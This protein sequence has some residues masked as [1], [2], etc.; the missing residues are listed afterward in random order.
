MNNAAIHWSCVHKGVV[1]TD[2]WLFYACACVVLAMYADEGLG[3]L[4]LASDES[5]EVRL[6]RFVKRHVD[7]IRHAGRK[8]MHQWW[9]HCAV[10][11]QGGVVCLVH[12][13][14]RHLTS[15][16]RHAL[17]IPACS[18]SE[19]TRVPMW[20][21]MALW[22]IE[23]IQMLAFSLSLAADSEGGECATSSASSSSVSTGGHHLLRRL[24]GSSTTATAPNNQT[25]DL[26]CTV[27]TWMRDISMMPVELHGTGWSAASTLPV[28]YFCAAVIGSLAL[29]LGSAIYWE[30]YGRERD[31]RARGIHSISSNGGTDSES[32]GAS[33]QAPL[34]IKAVRWLLPLAGLQVTTAVIWSTYDC[35]A[36]VSASSSS[37]S[38]SASAAS[39]WLGGDGMT[40]YAGTHIILAVAAF[41]LIPLQL[42]ILL[43][44]SLLITDADHGHT[45]SAGQQQQQRGNSEA[46][47]S[48]PDGG[49][50]AAVLVSP[51]KAS[52]LSKSHGRVAASMVVLKTL[53]SGIYFVGR[54]MQPTW[55][56]CSVQL[57]VG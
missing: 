6:A 52:V 8:V 14:M 41:L 29:L 44:T 51:H 27:V 13:W 12:V 36:D 15:R 30:A 16:L 18:V 4:A 39:M 1:N 34:L 40:C 53:T 31:A 46:S 17:T 2:I 33:L 56:V 24:G 49:A 23:V 10:P 21:P 11:M 26:S 42:G 45:S 3:P 28:W 37:S 9:V 48:A 43:C 20:W 38:A 32:H 47:S 50:S 22:I 57:A 5:N 7:R 35:Y 25:G 19:S 54:H 55:V